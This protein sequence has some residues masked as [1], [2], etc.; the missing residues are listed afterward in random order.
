MRV[1]VVAGRAVSGESKAIA[2]GDVWALQDVG[3]ASKRCCGYGEV[4][5]IKCSDLSQAA[6]RDLLSQPKMTKHFLNPIDKRAACV[7]NLQQLQYGR[8]GCR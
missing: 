1:E 5:Q 2:E 7:C 6:L 8:Q 4:I 3:S